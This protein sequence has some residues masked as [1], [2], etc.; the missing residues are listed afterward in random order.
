[1]IT[2]ATE[3]QQPA[4]AGMSDGEIAA[5]LNA[6]SAS[7]RRAVPLAA[8]LATAALNG[9]YAAVKAAAESEAAPAQVRG[10][11]ASVL[12]L[13][14]GVFQEVNLDDPRVQTNWGALTQAGVLTQVQASEID[15]L[16]DVPGRSRAQEIGLGTVTV[17]DILDARDWLA[18]Q[19][20]EATRRAAYDRIQERL[21]NSPRSALARLQIMRHDGTPAPNWAEVLEWL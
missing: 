21:I 20:A 13:L 17:E 10:V 18:A 7:T 16:A 4:Y 1:M 8:L 5:A 12:V 14:S 6:V 2:L 19:E 11:C 3:I 9:S 15:A